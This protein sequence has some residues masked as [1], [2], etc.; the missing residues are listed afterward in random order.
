MGPCYQRTRNQTTHRNAT[1]PVS[2]WLECI[3]LSKPKR[4]S[5]GSRLTSVGSRARHAFSAF[6]FRNRVARFESS[7]L[8]GRALVPKMLGRNM[9]LRPGPRVSGGRQSPLHMRVFGDVILQC[10]LGAPFDLHGDGVWFKLGW[11]FPP[12]TRA[13]S[14]DE[15]AGHGRKGSCPRWFKPPGS[16]ACFFWTIYQEVVLIGKALVQ[17]NPIPINPWG[18]EGTPFEGG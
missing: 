2:A 14:P 10:C 7:E 12:K 3:S 4:P 1:P 13:A 18:V 15:K 8:T 11:A 16:G 6:R 17:K 5:G 9:E